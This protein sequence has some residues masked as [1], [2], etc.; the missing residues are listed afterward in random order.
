VSPAFPNAV[1]LVPGTLWERARRV[2]VQARASGALL[3][4]ATQA[5][6]IEDGGVRFGVRVLHGAREKQRLAA[7][8][9]QSGGNPFRD[10]DPRL[11]VG[12]VSDSHVCLLNKFPALDGHLLIVTRAAAEQEAALERS[13]FEALAACLAEGEAL[14]FYNAGVRA[15]ASQP[16]RHLQL[17][18]LPL[19]AGPGAVPMEPRLRSGLPERGIGRAPGLPFVHALARTPQDPAAA[20]ALHLA[21]LGA[22]G[23]TAAPY[24][25]LVT[26]AWTLLVPRS[27]ASWEGIEVNA[28]GYAGALLVRDRA[29]LARLRRIGPLALLAGVGR[30]EPSAA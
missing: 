20:H 28:L 24:N 8:Q 6:V 21:M 9:A 10:P 27:R 19:G 25:L 14:G 1:R 4:I 13:D 2:A 16:H 7:A 29:G 11:V 5:E 15:G 3:P 30:Q 12:D 23:A 18:P 22:S 26:R 17:V